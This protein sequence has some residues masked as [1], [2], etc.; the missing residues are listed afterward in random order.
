MSKIGYNINLSAINNQAIIDADKSDA[1]MH[2]LMTASDDASRQISLWKAQLGAKRIAWRKYSKLEGN[3]SVFPSNEEIVNQWEH[4]GHKDVIR[5]D[6]ANEPALNANDVQTNKDYVA[7]RVDLLHKAG[8]QGITVAVGAFSVGT[9]H[10]D[11]IS[12]GIYDP[13]IRAVVEGGHYFSVHEYC[14]GIPGAGD[15]FE[16]EALLNPETVVAK[17]QAARW[18]FGDEYWLLR[19]SDRFVMQARQMGIADPQIIV[20]EAFIDLIPDAVDVLNKLRDEYGIP[21][22]NNDM[23]GVLAWRKYLAVAFPDKTYEQAIAYLTRFVA[24]KV[25]YPDYIKGVCLFALNK[26]WDEPEGHNW[27]N[28]ILD[29]FRNFSLP[30]INSTLNI[31]DEIPIPTEAPKPMPEWDMRR[32]FV[33]STASGGSNIRAGWNEEASIIGNIGADEIEVSLSK[34]VESNSI[35][36]YNWRQMAHNGIVGYI[37]DTNKFHYRFEDTPPEPPADSITISH[38]FAKAQADFYSSISQ[39]FKAQAERW[40]KLADVPTLT[41]IDAAI[42]SSNEDNE[43]LLNIIL[44]GNEIDDSD[45]LDEAV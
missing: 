6:P 35:D 23:R 28:D 25:F 31:P 43:T 4:E 8:S 38:D 5:D 44:N 15:V 9:P 33:S 11:M 36:I 7:N 2:T 30:H 10:H 40:Y 29:T 16:Y 13:L 14:P 34:N 22:Y 41:I 37:A 45:E 18:P 42:Y 39:Q 21:A 12:S 3:W 1:D 20:T 32:A 17:M 24:E 19:R 26:L 27:L